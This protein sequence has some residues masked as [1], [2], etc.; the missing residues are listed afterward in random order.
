MD[1]SGQ[2]TVGCWREPWRIDLKTV[3]TTPI[4]LTTV[5]LIA[6]EVA[7]AEIKR[8]KSA[9]SDQGQINRIFLLFSFFIRFF[10]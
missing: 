1:K 7:G 9:N 3:R 2:A 4:R 6:S 10:A 5:N 8:A